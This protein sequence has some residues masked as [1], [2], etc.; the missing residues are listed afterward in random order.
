MPTPARQ[1]ANSLVVAL[2][3]LCTACTTLTPV[4]ATP[5]RIRTE[6]RA[7]DTVRVLTADGA[8][9]RVKVEALGDTSLSGESQGSRIEIPLRDIRQIDVERVSAGKTTALVVTVVGLA[10]VAI[11]TGGGSHTAGYNR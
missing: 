4:M 8:T 3:C 10:A 1:I 9:H 5:E 2:V 11:A 7:G 6:V